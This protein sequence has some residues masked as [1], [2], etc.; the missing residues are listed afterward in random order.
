MLAFDEKPQISAYGEC[1]EF[2]QLS[3]ADWA[4]LLSE[5][6][7]VRILP[8][9]VAEVRSGVEPVPRFWWQILRT[10]WKATNIKSKRFS[11]KLKSLGANSQQPVKVT[12]HPAAGNAGDRVAKAMALLNLS[13]D[14]GYSEEVIPSIGERH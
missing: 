13:G 3:D 9:Q 12:M 5:A 4:G 14:I 8:L 6:G 1:L 2:L 10:Y 7:Q 11:K